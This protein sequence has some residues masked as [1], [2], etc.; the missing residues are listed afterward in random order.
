MNQV[1]GF[2]KERCTDAI[3]IGACGY[4]DGLGPDG[5]WEPIQV[6]TTVYSDGHIDDLQE[7]YDDNF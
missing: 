3:S 1:Y 6:I 5:G 2:D 4:A 7:C